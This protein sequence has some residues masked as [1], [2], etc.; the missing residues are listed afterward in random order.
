MIPVLLI[1]ELYTHNLSLALN[2]KLHENILPAATYFLSF[3]YV[4]HSLG[5]SLQVPCAR[6]ANPLSS[7]AERFH[8]S[9]LERAL[10]AQLIWLHPEC[11]ITCTLE[12]FMAAYE[13]SVRP[14]FTRPQKYEYSVCHRYVKKKNRLPKNLVNPNL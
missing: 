8:G 10:M 9:A 6:L 1:L 3:L 7:M 2:T 13:G 14:D 5:N 11:P 4:W 12:N